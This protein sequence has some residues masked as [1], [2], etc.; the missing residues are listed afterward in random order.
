MVL[1]EDDALNIS[2]MNPVP[3][4]ACVHGK[5]IALGNVADARQSFNHCG[6]GEYHYVFEANWRCVVS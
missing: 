6:Q 3:C 2:E 1:G 5:P 4:K